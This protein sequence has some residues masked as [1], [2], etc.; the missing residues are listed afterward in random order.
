[1]KIDVE[2]Y[3]GGLEDKDTKRI[4]IKYLKTL[5]SDLL[6]EIDDHNKDSFIDSIWNMLDNYDNLSYFRNSH[7][8]RDVIKYIEDLKNRSDVSD[9][10]KDLATTILM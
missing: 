7:K 1:M 3:I 8:K 4:A 10:I 2:E 9:K 6:D 5:N